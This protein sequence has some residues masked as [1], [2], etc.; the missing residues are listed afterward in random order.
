MC[1]RQFIF[2]LFRWLIFVSKLCDPWAGITMSMIQQWNKKAMCIPSMQKAEYVPISQK[3]YI[4]RHALLDHANVQNHQVNCSGMAQGT[5]EAIENPSRFS[6][7]RWRCRRCFPPPASLRH[8]RCG[9]SRPLGP[10]S[11]IPV[12]YLGWWGGDTSPK[13][14]IRSSRLRWST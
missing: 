7:R 11:C 12:S 8:W 14:I 4:D 6:A 13:S 1:Y 9:G 5:V 10:F 3:N 2:C